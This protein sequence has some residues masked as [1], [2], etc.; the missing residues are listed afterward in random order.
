MN[1]TKTK[2][3]LFLK[4]TFQTCHQP[5]PYSGLPGFEETYPSSSLFFPLDGDDTVNGR[6]GS[7]S[8]TILLIVST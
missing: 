4:K 2:F 1:K 5:S 8:L 6:A 7:S 3:P